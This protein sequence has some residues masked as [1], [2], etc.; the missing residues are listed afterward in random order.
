MKFGVI[1][2]AAGSSR[3]FGGLRKKPFEDL[4]GR[5]VWRRTVEHF[6]HRDD[7]SEVVLV[8]AADDIKEFRQQ[9]A[10]DLAAMDVVLATGGAT[11]ADSVRNGLAA[12]QQPADFVA[13]H[14]AARPVLTSEGISD[15]FAA[16]VQRGAVI[17]AIAVN[18]TVKRVND[19]DRIEATVDRTPLRLAQTPQVFRRDLLEHAYASVADPSQYTDEASLVESTGASVFVCEGWP[20]NIKITTQADLKLAELFLQE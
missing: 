1:I 5:A 19:D 9:F 16:A 2:P 8:L 3:R 6:L 15:V 14:D 18:S 4:A 11:R 17:P 7:V 10:T 20:M 12:L 13:V